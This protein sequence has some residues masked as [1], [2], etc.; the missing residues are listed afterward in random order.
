MIEGGESKTISVQLHGATRLQ[1]GIEAPLFRS[2]FV[3]SNGQTMTV[4]PEIISS[5]VGSD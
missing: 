1:K 2:V 3:F 4:V 5:G